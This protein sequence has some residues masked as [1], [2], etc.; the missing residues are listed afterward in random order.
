MRKIN[1]KPCPFCGYVAEL[2]PIDYEFFCICKKCGASTKY[3][4]TEEGAAEAW[5]K[6]A[7][8]ER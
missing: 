7:G 8:Q 5:N 4:E 2:L 6:Q 3:Y 1:L